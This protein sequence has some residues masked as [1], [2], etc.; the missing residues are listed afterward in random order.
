MKRILALIIIVCVCFAFV[1]SLYADGTRIPRAIPG[2][3][4]YGIYGDDE[5]GTCRRLEI[6]IEKMVEQN[7]LLRE[8]NELIRKQLYL[9]NRDSLEGVIT[10]NGGMPMD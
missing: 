7:G 8:Q 6:L 3:N 9:Q 10:P 1:P 5:D 2:Y 4:K